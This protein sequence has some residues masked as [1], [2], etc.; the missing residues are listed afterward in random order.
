MATFNSKSIFQFASKS[1]IIKI[2]LIVTI[3]FV[4]LQFIRITMLLNAE[5]DAPFYTYL[6]NKLSIPSDMSTFIRQPWTLFT[7]FFLDNS[8]MSIIGNMIWLWIF[9]TVIEDLKGPNRIMPIFI[10]GSIVGG[11]LMLLFGLVKPANPQFFTGASAGIM[12][13][14]FAALTF[15]P[16]YKFWWFLGIGIPIWVFVLLFV[17]LRLAAVQMN[18]IPFLF[19]LIGGLVIGLMYTN[20]LD[21]YFDSFTKFLVRSRSILDNRNFVLKKEPVSRGRIQQQVP[22]KRV[23][24]NPNKIDDILDKIHEKGIQALSKEERQILDEYSRSKKDS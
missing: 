23:Y 2:V 10:T 4:L 24:M 15:K 8:I 6:W 7:Y 9:G 11:I 5:S 1:D 14:A 16:D 19:M 13:V 3:L 21:R 20:V 18:N 17:G 22:F 12:A